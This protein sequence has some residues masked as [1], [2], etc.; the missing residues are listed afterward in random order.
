LHPEVPV[1]SSIGVTRNY[2]TRPSAAIEE[3]DEEKVRILADTLELKKL[4]VD[5]L[6]PEKPVTISSINC[7]R[8]YFDRPSAPGHDDYIHSKGHANNY[9]DNME[10]GYLVDH[11]YHHYDYDQDVSLSHNS[12][13]SQSDHFE[14]DEDVF[15]GFRESIN[16]FRDSVCGI[17]EQPITLTKEEQSDD[18]AGNLSRSPSSIMLFEE[19]AI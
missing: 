1:S 3:T 14:M 5:Y 2:F 10:H 16:A 19:A 7:A 6:H 12:F 15:H 13:H 4:A 18:K 11:D 8:N 17:H 9:Q